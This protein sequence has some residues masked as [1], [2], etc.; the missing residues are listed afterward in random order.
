MDTTAFVSA[1]FPIVHFFVFLC[2]P[3]SPSFLI[4]KNRKDEAFA[5]L[6]KIRTEDDADKELARISAEQEIHKEESLKD[7][8]TN[9][10]N[11]RAA[12]IAYG[13]RTIQQISGATAFT[14]FCETI[15][16]ETEDIIPSHISTLIYFS[17]QLLIA[18][19]M[20]F[21]VDSVGRKPLLLISVIGTAITL[22]ILSC[23]L[24]IK[25][26]TNIDVEDL[27][28]VPIVAL[29][30]YIVFFSIGI[31]NIPLLMIGEL[32]SPS[33][34]S[35]ALSIGTIYYSIIA[36]LSAKIFYFVNDA[37]GMHASFL[38]YGVMTSAS[39]FFVIFV[40]PETKGLNLEEIQ[41]KLREDL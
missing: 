26:R 10:I 1:V 9:K 33:I 27:K 7:L 2:M 17:I 20:I 13:L 40:V 18:F 6:L 21:I 34:K 38:L 11:R 23:F 19:L 14:F 28:C 37:F 24:V 16:E 3:E 39:T 22:L 29:F 30:S 4:R 12:F 5:T 41:R 31:R 25:N 15:F 32:F 36:L 35:L 8:F